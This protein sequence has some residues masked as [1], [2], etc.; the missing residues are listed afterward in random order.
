MGLWG[1]GAGRAGAGNGTIAVAVR[2]GS[3][4]W[5]PSV[6]VRAPSRAPSASRGSHALLPLLPLL[7]PPGP[8]S[9]RLGGG[10]KA[11]SGGAPGWFRALVFSFSVAA[12]A[13]PLSAGFGVRS[14]E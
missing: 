12:W 5:S 13:A 7:A 6:A 10:V 2:G 14:A 9:A 8:G 1:S 4:G 3:G 11:G